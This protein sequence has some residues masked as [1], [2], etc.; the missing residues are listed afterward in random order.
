[1]NDE[2]TTKA[3]IMTAVKWIVLPMAVLFLL[4]LYSIRSEAGE[5]WTGDKVADTLMVS[6][7]MLIVMDWAQTRESSDKGY[8][9]VG[10]AKN[11]IGRYPTTGDVNRYFIASL[12]QYNM[13]NYLLPTKLK[14]VYSGFTAAIEFSVVK[15]NYE[16]GVGMKF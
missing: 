10:A 6:A 12:I 13:V 15:G 9:E 7:N 3:L 11:F 5:F 2:F 4:M 16:I 1:M 14:K 8:E